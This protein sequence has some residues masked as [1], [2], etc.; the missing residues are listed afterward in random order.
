V[1]EPPIWTDQLDRIKLCVQFRDNFEAI[2]DE[3]LSF[4]ANCHPFMDY[5]KYANLYVNSWKAFP[6]SKFEGEHIELSKQSLS[7]QLETLVAYNRS[8]LPVLSSLI[9]SLENEGHLRNVFVSKLLPGSIINPHHGWTKDYLRVH[10]GLICDPDC[11]ITV[12]NATQTWRPGELLAFK[13]GGP[14]LHSVRH[15]GTQQRIVISFD[16]TLR[17]V[18]QFIPEI[19][20]T[21]FSA[22]DVAPSKMAL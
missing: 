1:N 14:F 15:D 17:Y 9:Q 13:D 5:P 3:V 2:R 11:R 21:N 20:G 18:S 12:G 19:V 22:N 8:K 10:M 6:L 4:I 16:L 7:F